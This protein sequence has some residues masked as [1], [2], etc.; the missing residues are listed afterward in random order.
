MLDCLIIKVSMHHENYELFNYRKEEKV[1]KNTDMKIQDL[2][3][4]QKNN[5]RTG[6]SPILLG[7]AVMSVSAG[8]VAD[9]LPAPTN[10]TAIVN[11]ADVNL[12]WDAYTDTNFPANCTHNREIQIRRDSGEIDAI[13]S[14]EIS[15]TD[16]GLGNGSYIYTIRAR[17]RIPAVPGP[18]GSPAQNLFSSWSNSAIASISDAT[19]TEPPS[20]FAS[21]TPALLWPPNGKLVPVTVTGTVTAGSGCQVPTQLSYDVV[22]EYGEYSTSNTAEINNGSFI[23]NLSLEASRLGTDTDGRSYIIDLSATS[24]GHDSDIESVEVLVPHDQR[25]R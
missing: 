15:Y 14:N 20:V 9:T 8:A 7:V 24:E 17:C 11:G 6:L 23:I 22:D 2:K 5:Y 25:K 13:A 19:C 12:N 3:S 4:I 21:V 10:L 16:S 18:D 1:M